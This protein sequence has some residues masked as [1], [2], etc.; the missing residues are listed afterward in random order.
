MHLAIFSH[1]SYL[2]DSLQADVDDD[3]QKSV[4]TIMEIMTS[5][6]HLFFLSYGVQVPGVSPAKKLSTGMFFFQV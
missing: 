5:F 6:L 1:G 4:V 3:N 2:S